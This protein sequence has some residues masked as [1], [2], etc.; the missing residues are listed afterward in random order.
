MRTGMYIDISTI[1]K[2]GRTYKRV[3][4]RESY[5]ENGK[6]K[7]R[8]IANLS[9]C[10]DQEIEAMK[11]AL[12]HK[13]DLTE[14]GSIRDD[15]RLCQGDS[16]GA[17]W[18]VYKMACRLGIA[19]ALGDSRDGKLALWQ[20]IARV[21]D[22]GSR[23]SA[24]RFAAHR[25][26]CDILDC[27]AFHEEHLY[28]NLDW[29]KDNQEEIEKKLFRQLPGREKPDL[30]LYDVT[31]SYLEGRHNELAA[32]GYNRDRKQGKKQIVIGLLCDGEGTPLS[33]EVFSG[34]TSDTKTFGQQVTKVVERFGAQAVTF[35]GD[36]GMIKGPQIEQLQQYTDHEFHYITAITKPQI[37]KLLQEDAIQI[38]LFDQELGEVQLE[39]GVRLVLRRNPVRAEEI[40]HS[41][42]DKYRSLLAL[43][44][45]QNR[46]LREHRRA[47]ISTAKKRVD[48]KSKKLKINAWARLSCQGRGLSLSKDSVELQE[49]E[50]LDG[51]YVLKTDLAREKVST[52]KTVQ[53]EMRPVNVRLEGRTRGHAFVVMMAYRI[54]KELACLWAPLD[55]TVQEGLAELDTLCSTEVS[56]SNGARFHRIPQPRELNRRLLELAGVQLPP[57]LPSKGIRVATKK[58]LPSQRKA[59]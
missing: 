34:N 50:K 41:R 17:V 24:V 28:A 37:E 5:R 23:L 40:K 19:S 29:L 7:K 35:V 58:T 48:D 27:D 25:G 51:C 6:V 31:S 15:L 47:K 22:Q 10:S 21:I 33:I 46:Y 32:F 43:V 11:L 57:I 9:A 53:L 26:A 14:L 8:T 1:T 55:V 54:V 3:L 42:D 45:E 44:E 2:N 20:V 52:S 13:E 36:R 4:L 18:L 39:E 38:S 56:I 16:V 59:A 30:F 12:E 49:E